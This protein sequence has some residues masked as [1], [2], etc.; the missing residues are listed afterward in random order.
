M[1]QLTAL[2]VSPIGDSYPNV[3]YKLQLLAKMP[4]I[5]Y[6]EIIYDLKSHQNLSKTSTSGSISNRLLAALK[7][8]FGHLIVLIRT[9]FQRPKNLYVAYP[10]IFLVAVI[11]FFSR[12]SDGM[13]IYL[14]AFISIYDTVVNDRKLISPSHW[15]AKLLYKIERY[16]FS[17]ATQVV[18]D[19]EENATYLSEL[20]GLQ[21]S[22]FKPIVLSIPSEAKQG[23]PTEKKIA[24]PINCIF[25][26][27]FVPLQGTPT[28]IE[29]AHLLADNALIRFTLIGDGQDA[30]TV[31]KLIDAYGL[32]N[33]TW[34]RGHFPTDFVCSQLAEAHICLG[35]FGTSAKTQR[36]LPYK[37]YY[38]LAFGL[39][40]ITAS[41]AT[42]S[43]LS[44]QILEAG[45]TSPFLTIKQGSS[46]QLAKTIE[47][48][49][50]QKAELNRMSLAAH[51]F[52]KAQLDDSAITRELCAL[53][54]LTE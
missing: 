47:L 30:D 31:A 41:T 36:V 7:I 46:E 12:R 26:G 43:R 2:A 27:T 11:G 6:S 14:D 17:C 38:A 35:I 51:S 32:K 21:K 22:K 20:F 33:I 15:L 45:K 54:E 25:V 9:L 34:H 10:G 50:Q 3:R 39:P 29:A 8:A 49:S 24:E 28:I 53:F 44:N 40:I 23:S 13:G 52:Y 5:Q 18:V 1:K 4:G 19:T 37:I 16:A 42:I 48:L